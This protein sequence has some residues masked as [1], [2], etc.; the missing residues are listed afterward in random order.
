MLKLELSGRK[1][2]YHSCVNLT[3]L[4][5]CLLASLDWPSF[6]TTHLKPTDLRPWSSLNSW[7]MSEVNGVF[8]FPFGT[9]KIYLSLQ[10][11]LPVPLACGQTKTKKASTAAS[12]SPGTSSPALHRR[13]RID[14]KSSVGKAHA[15]CKEK[16]LILI[17][18]L[19]TTSNFSC[20]QVFL[21]SKEYWVPKAYLFYPTLEKGRS[22][23]TVTVLT[24][25]L[26][27]FSGVPYNS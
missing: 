27:T 9:L 25:K 4:K 2:P 16:D 14:G 23:I 8:K 3:A 5:T 11:L 12:P 22:L 17:E 15:I 7:W 13:A 21:C 19:K 18:T 1:K 10:D 6:M 24:A 20:Q 26:D